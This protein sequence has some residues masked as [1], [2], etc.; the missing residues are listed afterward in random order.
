MPPHSEAQDA[1]APRRRRF[2]A[3]LGSSAGF[4]ALYFVIAVAIVGEE[5][6]TALWQ[7]LLCF[8]AVTVL[9]LVVG[10]FRGRGGADSGE[11][12]SSDP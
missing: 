2:V 9:T 1:K 10:T 5:L 12:D 11:D 7:S 6:P 3:T 8:V 4:S